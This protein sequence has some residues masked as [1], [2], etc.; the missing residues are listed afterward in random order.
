MIDL[1]HSVENKFMVQLRSSKTSHL[2]SGLLLLL[3]FSLCTHPETHR[4]NLVP[5]VIHFYIYDKNVPRAIHVLK[6][7]LTVPTLDL[8]SVKARNLLQ[9]NEKTSEQAQ[10]SRRQQ[11]YVIAAI[12]ADFYGIHG[13]PVGAQIADGLPVKAPSKHSLFAMTPSKRPYIAKVEMVARIILSHTEFFQIDGINRL[14]YNNEIILYNQ[15]YGPSTAT[16]QWGTE[17]TIQ[18]LQPFIVGQPIQ[19]IVTQIVDER[20]NQPIPP[21]DGCVISAHGEVAHL[22]RPK[23]QI[24]DTLSLFIEFP[25]IRE[26]LKLAVGGIPRL[27]RDGEISIELKDEGLPASFSTTRHPRTALGFTK[28]KQYLLLVTVDGRQPDYSVGMT[29]EELA[30]TMLELGCYQALNLDGGGSTTMVINN[31]VANRP[32]DPNGERAVANALLVLS[33]IPPEE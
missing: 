16:N 32:S 30:Q 10:R 9:G 3:F 15:F 33:S 13:I 21:T 27:I 4:K 23:I 17:I 14:R 2:L 28:D 6:I 8:A 18:F 24:Q 22:L 25:P 29:L 26:P 19:G 12:N 7:D 31:L 5:G 1:I 11:Q 20:G